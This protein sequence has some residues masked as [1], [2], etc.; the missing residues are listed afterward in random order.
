MQGKHAQFLFRQTVCF[1][2]EDQSS[3]SVGTE[4]NNISKGQYDSPLEAVLEKW[5][6]FTS[7]DLL[8]YWAT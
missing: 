2:F 6:K 7:I 5:V 8:Y 4:E 3:C 1:F